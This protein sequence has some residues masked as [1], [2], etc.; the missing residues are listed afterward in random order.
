MD[1]SIFLIARFRVVVDLEFVIV[2]LRKA[3]RGAHQNEARVI[4]KL[5]PTLLCAFIDFS[6]YIDF[7]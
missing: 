2:R 3:K 7:P 4:I 1:T 5:F 6:K